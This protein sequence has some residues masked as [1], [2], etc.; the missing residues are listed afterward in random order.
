MYMR[1]RTDA[2]LKKSKCIVRY[3]MPSGSCMQVMHRNEVKRYSQLLTQV[4][5]ATSKTEPLGVARGLPLF[6]EPA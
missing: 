1:D 2:T 6:T 5:M 3:E 4:T